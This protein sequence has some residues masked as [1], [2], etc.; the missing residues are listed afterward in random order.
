MNIKNSFRIKLHSK[1]IKI[2]ILFCIYVAICNSSSFAQNDFIIRSGCNIRLDIKGIQLYDYIK[3][4]NLQN[5]R[6]DSITTEQIGVSYSINK[7]DFGNNNRVD[8][9]STLGSIFANWTRCVPRTD[10]NRTLDAPKKTK[11][12]SP[13]TYIPE[14]IAANWDIRTTWSNQTRYLSSMDYYVNPYFQAFGGDPMGIPFAYGAGVGMTV[15]F[16][17]PYSGPM[18]TDFIKGGLHFALFEVAVTGRA[19]EFVLKY[20]N[21]TNRTEDFRSTWLGNW[22]NLFTPHLGIEF[23]LEIPVFRLSY[24]STID[25]VQEVTDNP[26]IVRN[27][28]TGEPMKN[29]V[30][31]GEYFGF[32]LRTPNL[33]FYNST[34][35]KFYFAKHFGEYHLGYAG[36]EMKVDDF[37][38][39]LRIDAMFAGKREFQLL[40]ELY[41][42]SPWKGFANKAFGIGPSFRFGKTPSN[43][44]GLIGAFINARIKIGDFFDKNIY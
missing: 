16:G 13:L 12:W 42:D 4:N 7:V 5:L 35:A 28:V 3:Y 30:V 20:A 11:I 21:G 17:T 19:K 24:F 1:F 10:E 38:F 33:I 26:I 36:R 15:A 18:E 8:L 29:N 41:L 27:E 6:N 43:N 32:E 23:A 34:R 22:N 39:D 9:N 44:F 2:L 25:T 31:R 37:I 14:R 40:T